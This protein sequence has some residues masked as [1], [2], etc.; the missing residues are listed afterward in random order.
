L[1][2]SKGLNRLKVESPIHSHDN[3][4]EVSIK[5]SRQNASEDSC[6][7]RMK[8]STKAGDKSLVKS[9]PSII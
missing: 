3:L 5:K 7:K 9:N 1:N 4:K 6:E 2:S 8:C